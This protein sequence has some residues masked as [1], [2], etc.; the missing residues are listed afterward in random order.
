MKG[1]R[2]LNAAIQQRTARGAVSASATRGPRSGGVAEAARQF[3][4]GMRLTTFGT[5][6]PRAFKRG[7]D[8]STRQLKDALPKQ[9][10]SWGLSRKILNIFLRDCFYTTYLDK[11][12]GLRAAEGL[13]EIPLDSITAKQIRQRT[14][15]L[16]R[17]PGVRKL[18][19]KVSSE[20]QDAAL[21]VAKQDYGVARV[22]LDAYWYGARNQQG[23][24]HGAL[25]VV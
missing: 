19:Q 21:R 10:T 11:A 6:D 24:R 13:F 5:R 14:P 16:P 9:G 8:H 23:S 12:Y 2:F 15:E 17:W 4:G 22:H 25:R 3:L 7:L 20:Y 18:I 1:R